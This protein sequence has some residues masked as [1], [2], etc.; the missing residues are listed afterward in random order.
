MRHWRIL[1]RALVVIGIGTVLVLKASVTGSISGAVTDPSGAAVQGAKVTLHNPDTGLRQEATTGS[2]GS[3]EFL[4]VPVG[5]HY[6]IDVEA[7]GF[8]PYTQTGIT[9]LV[10]QRLRADAQ[11]ALGTR[12]EEHTSELQSPAMISYAVFCWG[13]RRV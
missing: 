6:T 4:V 7:S 3:Y 5:E 1:G 10:N 12:S 2:D 11:L 13:C 9:L 8:K